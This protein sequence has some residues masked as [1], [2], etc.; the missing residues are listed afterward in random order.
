MSTIMK[1]TGKDHH[2]QDQKTV[3][4]FLVDLDGVSEYYGVVEYT[5]SASISIVYDTSVPVERQNDH[6]GVYK[7][8]SGAVT[9][10][11]RQS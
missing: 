7:L 2:P 8:L 3:Y 10:E 9:P 11:M 5:Y 6:D 1:Y 4:W